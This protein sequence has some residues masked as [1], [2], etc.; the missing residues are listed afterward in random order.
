MPIVVSVDRQLLFSHILE[1]LIN[2]LKKTFFF[3]V[4]NI[5]ILRVV[6]TSSSQARSRTD[7][8]LLCMPDISNQLISLVSSRISMFL[9]N[10]TNSYPSQQL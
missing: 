1:Q 2:D 9:A 4:R 7:D 10:K 5:G 3:P 6:I 8:L